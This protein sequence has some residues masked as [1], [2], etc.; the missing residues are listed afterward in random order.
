MEVTKRKKCPCCGSKKIHTMGF[1]QLC[2][3]CDWMNSMELVC[4]G[5]FEDEMLEQE[6]LSLLQVII[7]NPNPEHF[8]SSN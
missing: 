1:D 2:L 7:P 6:E 3:D 4:A 8:E 5:Q